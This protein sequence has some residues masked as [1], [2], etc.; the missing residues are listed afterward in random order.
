MDYLCACLLCLFVLCNI[1]NNIVWPVGE[2]SLCKTTDGYHLPWRIESSVDYDINEYQDSQCTL[3]ASDDHGP[4][5]ITLLSGEKAVVRGFTPASHL[6]VA[7]LLILVVAYVAL[8]LAFPLRRQPKVLQQSPH[9]SALRLAWVGVVE[10]Y[11]VYSLLHGLHMELWHRPVAYPPDALVTHN[12]AFL[13]LPGLRLHYLHHDPPSVEHGDEVHTVLHANHG[14][15]ASSLSWHAVLPTLSQNLDAVTVAHDAPGETEI[16]QLTLVNAR[17]TLTM[18][19]V[20]GF[21]LTEVHHDE[22]TD[23]ESFGFHNSARLATLLLQRHMDSDTELCSTQDGAVHE[24]VSPARTTSR[25]HIFVG[26]SMGTMT[27]TLMALELAEKEGAAAGEILLVLEAPAILGDLTRVD[28]PFWLTRLAHAVILGE[29]LHHSK[30]EE[31]LEKEQEGGPPH[32][33][34]LP[35]QII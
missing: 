6:E 23:H 15:G 16:N 2:P 17:P 3:Q 11:F 30:E 34:A 24:H 32:L 9:R 35:T 18:L 26:H 27:S 5:V 20:A 28:L 33:S 14:F 31:A 19:V 1:H 13:E 8:R 29:H 22:E 25:R 4:T 21:G 10:A 7:L 12:S